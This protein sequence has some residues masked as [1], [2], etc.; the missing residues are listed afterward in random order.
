[1]IYAATKPQDRVTVCTIP[2]GSPTECED[3]YL[4]FG[5]PTG[6]Y[7]STSNGG[8]PPILPLGY[9][10]LGLG[11]AW[12]LGPL[13]DDDDERIP[14]IEAVVGLVVFGASFGISLALDADDS[15]CAFHQSC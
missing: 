14:W 7:E 2:L 6:E 9:S 4:R 13:L 8:G 12:M 15:V 11:T 1:M 10:L 3:P 5:A